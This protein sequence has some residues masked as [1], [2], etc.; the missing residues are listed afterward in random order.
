MLVSS[1]RSRSA[2]SVFLCS[3]NFFPLALV[4]FSPLRTS[5]ILSLSSTA[6][7][8]GATVGTAQRSLHLG[9]ESPSFASSFCVTFGLTELFSVTINDEQ[10][11]TL[12]PSPL[13]P[14]QDCESEE[15]LR[16]RL[17]FADV[18]GRWRGSTRVFARSARSRSSAIIF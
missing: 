13:H 8:I 10:A 16:K 18:T 14:M 17:K 6:E 9:S 11:K 5:S 12:L 15:S 7:A 1:G 3:A 2:L 4:I